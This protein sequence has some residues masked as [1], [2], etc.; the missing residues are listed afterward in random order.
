MK[1][2]VL[3][4]PVEVA[5]YAGRL[6]AGLRELD[7]DVDTLDVTSNRYGFE[8]ASAS[9]SAVAALNTLHSREP[10]PNRLRRGAGRVRSAALRLRLA[11]VG[12]SHY[13]A[14]IYLFGR[15]LL[16][17][18]DPFLARL[19]GRRILF[20]FLGSDSRPPYLNGTFMHKTGR[21][22]MLRARIFTTAVHH[23]VRRSERWAHQIVCHPAS[24][25]FFRRPFVNWLAIGMP[26]TGSGRSTGPAASRDPSVVRILHAP[27]DP[28]A[29]GTPQIVAAIETLQG[30]GLPLEL[31]TLSGVS[32]DAVLTAIG[33][34]DL[35][36]DQVFSDTPFPGFAS[37]ACEQGVPALVFGYAGPFLSQDLAEFEV[38]A[39]HYRD[40][41]EVLESLRGLATDPGRRQ[42]LAREQSDFCTATSSPRMVAERMEQVIRDD[43][44]QRWLVDP[45]SISYVL[46]WG[47]SR[48]L[49]REAL[50]RYVRRW[51]KRGLLLPRQSA[52]RKAVEQ[53]L[54]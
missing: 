14:Y 51:G 32:N 38:P 11:L 44:P 6:A 22:G 36:V 27:T 9:F 26:S 8:S 53:L 3:I 18:V 39:R 25:Q 43:I 23:R 35:I 21:W 4:L 13:D 10:S 42:Q 50:S 48:E 31:R 47:M 37:E 7:W 46:G 28:V 49:V 1:G 20:V 16:G 45:A 15:T 52:A 29:K 41:S 2:R 17:P 34:S 19:R 30:E 40:P 5:G 33:E 24:G 54:G 12:P